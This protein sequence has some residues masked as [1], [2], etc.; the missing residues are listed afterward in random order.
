LSTE[1][2]KTGTEARRQAIFSAGV[3]CYAE[4]ENGEANAV[5]VS[6]LTGEC[7]AIAGFSA[8]QLNF[9]FFCKKLSYKA[10][11][12]FIGVRFNTTL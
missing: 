11:I 4:H 7:Q 2:V 9:L 10:L 3:V 6:V 12:P 8:L 1:T 5:Y